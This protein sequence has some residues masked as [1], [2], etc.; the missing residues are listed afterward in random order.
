MYQDDDVEVT[1]PQCYVLM[2]E[3]MSERGLKFKAYVQGYIKASYPE[4][5]LV[6]IDGMKAICKRK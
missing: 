5:E 1:I 4:L 2:T 3:G 6:K